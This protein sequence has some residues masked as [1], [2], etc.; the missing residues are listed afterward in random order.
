MLFP[1]LSHDVGKYHLTP[2]ALEDLD[3]IADYSLGRWGA[4]QTQ[5]YLEQIGGRMQWLA[6]N[7]GIGR[8]RDDVADGYRSFPEGKH[9]IFYLTLEDGIAIIG[10]PHASMDL[11]PDK[12]T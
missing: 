1:E 9:I 10:I 7:P 6:E 12:F 3:A 4:E 11:N 5:S 8:V 2:R